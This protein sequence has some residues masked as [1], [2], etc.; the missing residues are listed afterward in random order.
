VRNGG[1]RVEEHRL[2]RSRKRVIY[3]VIPNEVRN[4]S[5]VQTG[6]KRDSSARS[7]PRNDKNLSFS[8]SC[9][10]AATK[11]QLQDFVGNAR[12]GAPSVLAAGKQGG[13]DTQIRIG[14]YPALRLP[15]NG[16]G[17]AHNEAEMFA[18]GNGAKM[19]GTDSRQSRNLVFGENL[20]S[21]LYGDHFL[22]SFSCSWTLVPRPFSFVRNGIR[23]PKPLI[24]RAIAL[25]F[26]SSRAPMPL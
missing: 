15:P 3:F 20:L 5:L 19:L 2:N 21:G 10:A 8:A 23:D 12:E 25:P 4:L 14:E 13:K 1:E 22:P 26:T 11:N 6:E 24:F 16:S 18:A 7:A 17:S 9:E